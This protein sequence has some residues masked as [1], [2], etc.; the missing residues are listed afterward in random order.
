[1]SI[2]E[3]IHLFRRH[4]ILAPSAF[5]AAVLIA[6]ATW[7]VTPTKY[8]SQ[9][10]MTMLNSEAETNQLGDLGNPYLAFSSAL[11]ADVDFLTR[12]LVSNDSA[13]QLHS[14]G[15]TETYTAAFANNA[16]G[17]FML[18]TAT[19]PNR[20][21]VLNSINTLVSFAQSRW[22]QVQRAGNAPTK[23]IVRLTSITPPSNPAPVKK[24]KIELV[25]GVGVVSIVIAFI[26]VVAVD[27]ARRNRRRPNSLQADDLP[28][29]R[30]DQ[31][32][33]MR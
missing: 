25:G 13:Q 28:G 33:S 2:R 8:Q 24:T 30:T 15:V 14:L 19:G 29:K 20:A 32:P 4:W 23:S 21:H 12:L 6:V 1:M 9:V 27:N 10:Q 31:V 16:L 3:L 5:L 7:V 17:P 18:I 11:S 26:L 22:Y